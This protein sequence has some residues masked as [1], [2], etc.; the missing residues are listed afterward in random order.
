M[1][2]WRNKS[3]ANDKS[4]LL[5]SGNEGGELK[6]WRKK[7]DQGQGQGQGPIGDYK[8]QSVSA[9][10]KGPIM[11]VC[12]GGNDFDEVD[13]E[14]N[15]K[16]LS[17]NHLHG[18]PSVQTSSIPT[19][20][21]DSV[22]THPKSKDLQN[23]MNK[24]A[25]QSVLKG[26]IQSDGALWVTRNHQF[27]ITSVKDPRSKKRDVVVYDFHR[28]KRFREQC[29][30]LAELHGHEDFIS[31]MCMMH[32][33]WNDG[34]NW[35]FSGS[36]DTTIRCWDLAKRVLPDGAKETQIDH[37]AEK[38]DIILKNEAR[39]YCLAVGRD[40]EAGKTLFAGLENG[41]VNVWL[42]QDHQNRPIDKF[43]VG[44]RVQSVSTSRSS[45]VI[46]GSA[47]N[48]VTVWE[49]RKMKFTL[50]HV[51]SEH[52][53][54]VNAVFLGYKTQNFVSGSSDCMLFLWSLQQ[55]DV[56]NGHDPEPT[57]IFMGH[58]QEITSVVLSQNSQ[59]IFSGDKSGKICSWDVVSGVC[60][61]RVQV[62][63]AEITAIHLVEELNEE[64]KELERLLVSVCKHGS[65]RITRYTNAKQNVQK[66]H[67]MSVSD[68]S[69]SPDGKF[70]LSSSLDGTIRRWDL[71]EQ[72][73]QRTFFGH[74][75]AVLSIDLS[76][77]AKYFVSASTDFSIRVWEIATGKSVCSQETDPSK[78]CNIQEE[79]HSDR[80]TTVS[81]AVRANGDFVI[82]SGGV[83]HRVCIWE[84]SKNWQ[85]TG[86]QLTEIARKQDNSNVAS[87]A[88]SSD[89]EWVAYGSADGQL[90]LWVPSMQSFVTSQMEH[91][92]STRH[93]KSTPKSRDSKKVV[94]WAEKTNGHESSI[95]DLAHDLKFHS[96]SVNSVCFSTDRQVLLAGSS[97]KMVSMWLL[98]KK[99]T[100]TRLLKV[101]PHD[102]KVFSVKCAMDHSLEHSSI[103]VCT[104]SKKT[105]G[106]L[107][108][109]DTCCAAVERRYPCHKSGMRCLGVSH[110]GHHVLTGG[111]HGDLLYWDLWFGSEDQILQKHNEGVLCCDISSDGQKIVSG[112]KDNLIVV[113]NAFSGKPDMLLHGHVANVSTVDL[114]TDNTK[115]LSGSWDATLFFWDL[116]S[117]RIS[118]V[119][120]GHTSAIEQ[121]QITDDN[122]KAVS[123]SR[124]GKVI[125]WD[126]IE[127][128]RLSLVDLDAPIR[129]LCLTQTNHPQRAVL[130]CESKDVPIRWFTSP[131]GERKKDDQKDNEMGELPSLQNHHKSKIRFVAL[132]RNDEIM[133]SAGQ[134][135]DIVEWSCSLSADK[136]RCSAIRVMN[137]TDFFP[138]W[139]VYKG[140]VSMA[141]DENARFMMVSNGSNETS[142]WDFR[143]SHF[144]GNEPL[145]LWRDHK[146]RVPAVCLT[147]NAK[148]AISCS[149]DK[150]L[151]VHKISESG[152][153]ISSS[154]WYNWPCLT[155]AS[156]HDDGRYESGELLR[157][158]LQSRPECLFEKLQPLGWTLLHWLARQGN[159]SAINVVLE[160]A[161]DKP[162][163]ISKDIFRETP[164]DS[165]RRGKRA[166]LA[167]RMMAHF[168]NWP[169]HSMEFLSAVV[170]SLFPMNLASMPEFLDSRLQ[171]PLPYQMLPIPD[172]AEPNM[173]HAVLTSTF[174]GLTQTKIYAQQSIWERIWGSSKKS[175]HDLLPVSVSCIYLRNFTRPDHQLMKNLTK[176]AN[177]QVFLSK[178]VQIILLQKWNTF[179][180]NSHIQSSGIFFL[181]LFFFTNMC[182]N[183]NGGC[184]AD[185]A[186]ED[187]GKWICE[188]GVW[189][190]CA[191]A[192]AVYFFICEI[193]QIISDGS[194]KYLNDIWN[195]IDVLANAGVIFSVALQA[196]SVSSTLLQ[197]ELHWLPAFTTL[198]LWL[199]FLFFMRGFRGTGALVRMIV[200]IGYDI[201]YF[202]LIMF[203][204][205]MAFSLANYTM[206]P[207][208]YLEADETG[209]W[210]D[211]TSVSYF[212]WHV[213]I[214]NWVGDF[215]GADYAHSRADVI[216]FLCQSVFIFVVMLN[217]LIALMGDTFAR[218]KARSEIAYFRELAHVLCEIEGGLPLTEH[219]NQTRFPKYLL[220]VRPRQNDWRRQGTDP[221]D[222]LQT[223]EGL[224]RKFG[225][226]LE[227]NEKRIIDVDTKFMSLLNQ[228]AMSKDG[229]REA[230]NASKDTDPG[231]DELC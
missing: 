186:V 50:S 121:A 90:M 28:D 219:Q 226:K 184:K 56:L 32:A 135:G 38:E 76:P 24:G 146:K 142:L 62:H 183:M 194:E 185:F 139:Y 190:W 9:C 75:A 29:Q 156:K 224:F 113:W 191:A 36:F 66:R 60:D 107:L 126:L 131:H 128:K 130:G 155:D 100:D 228:A 52:D 70:G 67:T 1:Q 17:L 3:L 105:G 4:M 109:W 193:K 178:V 80:V 198:L 91:E 124:G 179:G 12:F 95:T 212:M 175:H 214:A 21:S 54:N 77:D 208:R 18:E 137:D 106:E 119:L 27:L 5:A 63:H 176:T 213:Y 205:T 220:S 104:S 81:M 71:K 154:L 172:H 45:S 221:V 160:L 209:A 211:H 165:A 204:M 207:D 166:D 143:D 177:D 30:I 141:I 46:V 173:T 57:Q 118:F 116:K 34:G 171:E 53:G 140:I 93:E 72:T 84:L 85:T 134:S 218:V 180:L 40:P 167:D 168:T 37:I 26:A 73:L 201:R 122:T 22:G 59:F 64:N 7:I 89:T 169:K 200:E 187:L 39:V 51:L 19:G 151:A 215:D 114:S 222:K 231:N 97:D 13:L 23:E 103:F 192:T 79:G 96:R 115:L 68:V 11:C 161:G 148:V 110:D 206:H 132:R 136:I 58:K 225:E 158:L 216:L 129:C 150:T 61:E 152:K 35:L 98:G 74:T 25:I 88:F 188:P 170:A 55:L 147:P 78:S 15:L 123:A 99:V 108:V 162:I 210:E 16:L 43:N 92:K 47:N 6:C 125:W 33:D 48:T 94:P 87:V 149:F 196:P 230:R 111:H 199:Q 2:K 159:L 195:W 120:Q 133:I 229:S 101:L 164:L 197:N 217:L 14:M 10:S 202:L 203:L 41:S 157:R 86:S 189:G 82:A 138:A 145:V 182:F 227:G 20:V 31:S 153:P 181:Q 223:L 83:D 65:L 49:K 127:G 112:G 8:E 44:G 102:R 144:H 69:I 174:T 42:W 163:A 117:G